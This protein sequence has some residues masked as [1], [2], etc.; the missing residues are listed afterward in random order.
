MFGGEIGAEI[1]ESVLVP[2]L[3][4]F[5]AGFRVLRKVEMSALWLVRDP[6][7]MKSLRVVEAATET[8]TRTQAGG[9]RHVQQS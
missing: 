9:R 6:L 2:S 3:G 1:R 8:A 4:Q 5:D 7:V